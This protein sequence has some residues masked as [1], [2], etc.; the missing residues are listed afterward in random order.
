[1]CLL[2]DMCDLHRHWVVALR[3]RDVN[4][5]TLSGWVD[6][7]TTRD[8][9]RSWSAPILVGETG[10]MNGNPPALCA[11]DA[12]GGGRLCCVYG[13]RNSRRMLARF[14]ETAGES[15]GEPL[16]L[17]DDYVTTEHMADLG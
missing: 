7:L 9:G 14:S 11:S 1:M 10:L 8:A 15:W 4:D 13:E 3:R 6:V 16:T 2:I 17:R 12:G 5:K